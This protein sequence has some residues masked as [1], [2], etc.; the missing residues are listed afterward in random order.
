M[1]R[2]ASFTLGR[3]ILIVLALIKVEFSLSSDSLEE[4]VQRIEKLEKLS[5][6]GKK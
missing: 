6:K 3:T 2:P 1:S 5:K 4:L